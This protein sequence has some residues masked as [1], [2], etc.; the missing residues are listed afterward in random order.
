MGLEFVGGTV[1]LTAGGTDTIVLKFPRTADM[2][3]FLVYS[4]GRVEITSLE[5]EGV[6]DY[7]TGTIELDQLKREGNYFE[8]P[9]PI[10]YP[11][12]TKFA[13][14]LKDISG[15]TNVVYFAV[16]MKW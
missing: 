3:G 6:E 10:P 4:T 16:L 11:K 12:G 5:L 14:G 8:L 2:I 7:L 9:E 1:S 13:I 15:A